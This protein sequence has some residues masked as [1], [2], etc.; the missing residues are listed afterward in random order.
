MSDATLEKIGRTGLKTIKF[1]TGCG[2]QVEF[3]QMDFAHAL[4]GL[5]RESTAWAMYAYSNTFDEQSLSYLTSRLSKAVRVKYPKLK[6]KAIV[7]L[8]KITLRESLRSGPGE[9][10]RPVSIRIK[11][12]A[13]GVPKSTYHDNKDK[14]DEVITWINACVSRWENQISKVVNNH[15]S[16]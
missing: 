3:T 9:V 4:S 7:G 14:Y 10:K 1:E 2:G 15:F 13:M 12:A 5:N 16:H 8:V 6:P 11:S